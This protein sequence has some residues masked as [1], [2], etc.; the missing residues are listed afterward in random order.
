[1]MVRS[2]QGDPSLE[3]VLDGNAAAGLLREIFGVEMTLSEARCASCGVVSRL[4]ELRVFGGA[5]GD[6]MR[7]PMCQNLMMR[8]MSG[9]NALWLDMQGVSYLRK[10]R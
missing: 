9:E 6:I 2:S 5:M 8:I 1:M 3:L 4:G 7:C 10:E